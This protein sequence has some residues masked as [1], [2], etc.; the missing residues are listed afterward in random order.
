M[1]LLLLSCLLGAAYLVER[2]DKGR[3]RREEERLQREGYRDCA[4]SR[5]SAL[6]PLEQPEVHYHITVI[7]DDFPVADRARTI[8][9]RP[10]VDIAD[11][12][13]K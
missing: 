11:R 4:P 13:R 3:R 7:Q 12:L 6:V 1:P 8:A 2:A 10:P 5:G 9:A